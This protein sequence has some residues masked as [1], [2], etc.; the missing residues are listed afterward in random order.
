MTLF[1]IFCYSSLP[2]LPSLSLPRHSTREKSAWGAAVKEAWMASVLQLPTWQ[3]SSSWASAWAAAWVAPLLKLW[4][5]YHRALMC[6]ASPSTSRSAVMAVLACM[7]ALLES[8]HITPHPPRHWADGGG[9]G[10]PGRDGAADGPGDGGKRDT[11]SI[12]CGCGA[13][14]SVYDDHQGIS[15]VAYISHLDGV[16]GLG[17]WPRGEQVP[18]SEHGGVPYQQTGPVPGLG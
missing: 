4:S 5:V 9:L 2:C 15:V 16:V 10:P 13:L 6:L 3:T 17:P 7:G 14:S 1:I 12:A 8:R 18:L 11:V